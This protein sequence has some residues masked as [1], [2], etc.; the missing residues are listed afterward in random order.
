M[1][2][3]TNVFEHVIQ[4]A[5][6]LAEQLG[7]SQ[8]RAEY[9]FAALLEAASSELMEQEVVELRQQLE[10]VNVKDFQE[11]FARVKS[12]LHEVE[13]FNTL[14]LAEKYVN[15]AKKY[16]VE[17]YLDEVSASQMAA[18]LLHIP[19]EFMNAFVEKKDET[20]CLTREESDALNKLL[21]DFKK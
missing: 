12:A 20:I 13:D 6:K 10:D 17:S 15:I 14:P 8:E 5:K 21:E 11:T 4:Q 16:A 18:A 3:Y 2:I 19:T 9:Y 7:D 1:M